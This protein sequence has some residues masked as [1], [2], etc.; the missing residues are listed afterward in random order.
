MDT[1]PHA[2]RLCARDAARATGVEPEIEH[3]APLVWR[4]ILA[5]RH[6]VASAT[7]TTRNG[8]TR[9]TNG[10][11]AIDGRARPVVSFDRLRDLWDKHER[12]VQRKELMAIP[13]CRPGQVMPLAARQLHHLL[14]A[15]LG[16]DLVQAGCSGGQWVIGADAPGHPG[17]GLRFIFHGRSEFAIQ[18]IIGGRDMSGRIGGDVARAISLLLTG[19]PEEAAPA[20]PPGHAAPAARATTGVETR[21]MVVKRI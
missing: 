19:H 4:V 20:V 1:V 10:F 15:Q 16:E 3:P 5:G 21:K 9:Y 11:L 18:A 6:I 17:D 2:V 12:G 7:Y 13:P 14:T 8:A